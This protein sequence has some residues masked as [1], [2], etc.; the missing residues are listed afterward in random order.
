M[1]SVTARLSTL[2]LTPYGEPE[3]DANTILMELDKGLRSS[4][5]G[6]QCESIVRFQKLLEKY[7][8]PILVNSAFLKLADVFRIGSNFLR[9]WILKV[10]QQ[11]EKHLDKILS[12]DDFLRRIFSVIYSND[13]VARA[14]TLRTLGSFASIFS[15]RKNVHHSILNGLD[16]HDLVEQDAAIYAAT[17]FASQSKTFASSICSKVAD[18]IQKLETPIDMK[19]KLIPICQHMHHDLN[20]TTKVREVCQDLLL[21]YPS[22]NFVTITL[23]TLTE[24]SAHCLVDIP[25]QVELLLKH[26]KV[27]TRKPVQAAILGNLK[28][29]ADKGAHMWLP[30]NVEALCCFALETRSTRL[31][32]CTLTV[33]CSLSNSMAVTNF[34]TNQGSTVL[35]LCEEGCFHDNMAVASK[36]A[37]ILTHLAINTYKDTGSE[38]LI[39]DATLALE[40]LITV[41]SITEVSTN[42]LA[43]KVVL[44]TVVELCQSCPTL[45]GTFVETIATALTSASG[46]TTLLLAES[47]CALCHVGTGVMLGLVPDLVKKL[48]DIITNL[49]VDTEANEKL[50]TILAT[51]IF[52]ASVG[53]EI[54]PQAKEVILD[55]TMWTNQWIAY[56][57]A[58][59]ASRYGQHNTAS[60]IYGTLTNKV[61]T[62]NLHYW[63]SALRHLSQG[64]MCLKDIKGD[65]ELVL[66]DL[67]DAGV[68]YHQA[69]VMLQAASDSNFSLEFPCQF[70]K[71]RIGVLEALAQLVKTCNTLKLSPPPAIAT[72]LAEATGQNIVKCGRVVEQLQK[73]AARFRELETGYKSL[74]QMSFDADPVT[75]LN[76]EEQQQWC[77]LMAGMIEAMFS[78]RT[79]NLS[80]QMDTNSSYSPEGASVCIENQRLAETSHDLEKITE[81]LTQIT[82][83]LP[84]SFQHMQCLTHAACRITATPMLFPRYFFQQQQSTDVKLAI[85]P[86]TKGSSDPIM[87]QNNTHLT[88][89]V[90]GV[91]QHAI[92][93]GLYRKVNSITIDVASVLQSRSTSS[94]NGK[95]SESSPNNM[96]Q[97]CQ[98]HNDYFCVEFLLIFPVTGLHNV[99]IDTSIVDDAGIQWHT[100]PKSTLTVK[101]YDETM[102]KS[103]GFSSRSQKSFGTLN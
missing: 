49:N 55:F 32:L 62:E 69:Y 3:K 17:H 19:L 88:V 27:E 40:S 34:D 42:Q 66:K 10:V 16:S 83:E 60:Q 93:Q 14:I 11:S 39:Q 33:L 57:I 86:Q 8:F 31:R 26:L 96:H 25:L 74:Y 18:L 37:L 7:P 43:P 24:L 64:E 58:R 53:S 81:T 15:E 82:S 94:S 79:Q 4:K 23:H 59:Q 28:V 95:V 6:E 35:R 51:L 21:N 63:L 71:L 52:E 100:G 2:G 47:L 99:T 12:V 68:H 77:K 85:S 91:I 76:I 98:P 103:G 72:S 102:M 38:V 75:L 48:E 97:T 41:T 89:K 30:S 5:V 73:D 50:A 92:Q 67:A 65:L 101:S 22:K 1:A 54:M 45:T 78:R 9:L 46:A 70:T 36:S 80:H 84:V 13:P 29:L 87:V 90:E 61:S 20:M 44:A 56:K